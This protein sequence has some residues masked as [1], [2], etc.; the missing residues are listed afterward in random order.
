MLSL[1]DFRMLKNLCTEIAPR[2]SSKQ[3]LGF[4]CQRNVAYKFTQTEPF[5]LPHL[6]KN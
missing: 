5:E 1:S 2:T 4:H 3:L 6:R